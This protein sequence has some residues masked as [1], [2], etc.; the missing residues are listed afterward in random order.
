M[1]RDD[2]RHGWRIIGGLLITLLWVTSTP[3]GKLGDDL[4]LSGF[5][6]Q[7]YLNSSGNNYLIPR[8]INGSAEFTEAAI[9]ASA[10]PLEHLRVGVQFMARN[11]GDVGNDQVYLDWAYGDYRWTD[12]FGLRAGKIK[13]PWGLY[14]EGRDVDMLRTSVFLPQSLYNENMRSLILAYDG[15][16]AYGNLVLDDL[17]DLDYQAY[18][19]TLS[20]TDQ[21]QDLWQGIYDHA[22]VKSESLIGQAV[23]R[24]Q[25]LP[26]G[27][28]QATYYE[29]RDQEVTFPWIWGGSLI[30]NTPMDGLRLG[31]TYLNGRFHYNGTARYDVIIS[32]PGEP[33]RYQ[34]YD[35]EVD[36]TRNMDFLVTASVEY[37]RDPLTLA[38]EYHHDKISIEETQGWYWMAN[39]QFCPL[40]TLGTYYSVEWPNKDDRNGQTFVDLG[41]PDH[42][43]WQ[44]DFVLSGRF[45]LYDYWLL[46]LEYHFVDGAAL[47]NIWDLPEG[48]FAERHW[49]MF[50]AKTTF[51]F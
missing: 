21:A 6:S 18:G 47:V 35:L 27:S 20:S 1:K 25:G 14:N 24:E 15:V 45:D 19:G 28:S 32:E 17:G 12:Y 36:D 9:I 26:A 39:Y 37:T 38:W 2:K 42:Y 16:G 8:S 10:E 3:A 51:H 23:D 49:G 43:G 41:L 31:G 44:K 29:S 13:M 5:V 30:W 50:T 4:F 34:P 7:G 22:A 11:F 33:D 40:F 48:E 46:K